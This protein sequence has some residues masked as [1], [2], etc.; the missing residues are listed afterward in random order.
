MIATVHIRSQHA[1]KGRKGFSGPNTYVAVT[2][3]PEEAKVP[4]AL[5]RMV[6]ARRGIEIRYFGEGYNRYRGPKSSLGKAISAAKQYAA[7][8]NGNI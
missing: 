1:K 4:Y 3:A 2:L 5:N 7:E 8:K 6:L